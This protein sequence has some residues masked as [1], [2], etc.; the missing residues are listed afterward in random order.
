YAFT[1]G[2]GLLDVYN[3]RFTVT[4]DY[5]NGI[6]AYF[7]TI[8]QDGEN[9]YPYLMGPNYYGVVDSANFN[10]TITIP[11]GAVQYQPV[12]EPGAWMLA[13]A[14]FAGSILIAAKKTRFCGN[15]AVGAL[16]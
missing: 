3:G 2:S 12:P 6:Y 8:L 1:S 16:N 11:A 9:A 4:P 15:E 13:L 10:Q 5:P 14:G 7:A